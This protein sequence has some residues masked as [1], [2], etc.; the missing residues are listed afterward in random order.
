MTSKQR[1]HR[2]WFRRV[3]VRFIQGDKYRD[4]SLIDEILSRPGNTLTREELE[5]P[6]RSI[7]GEESSR[8][9]CPS[10]K[11]KLEPNEWVWS[12]G[13]YQYR[14][15]NT[16]RHFCKHC[17]PDI[18]RDLDV[19]RDQCGCDFELVIKDSIHP[20]WLTLPQCSVSK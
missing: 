9:S 18:Q 16:V 1:I 12:W 14:R 17:F 15:W 8:K 7:I 4:K 19:H 3:S 11:D 13:E 5:Q 10:C 20:E 6:Y 2:E